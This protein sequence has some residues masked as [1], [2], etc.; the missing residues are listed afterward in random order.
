[1][2]INH[3]SLDSLVTRQNAAQEAMLSELR[4]GNY[5]FDNPLVKL[6]PYFINPYAAVVLFNTPEEVAVTVRVLGK[7]KEG[8]MEHTFPRA[9]EHVLPVLGLYGDYAN[10][11][12]IELYRGAKHTIT[13]QTEPIGSQVPELVRMETTAGYLRDQI[14]IVSPALDANSA[15]LAPPLVVE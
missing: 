7:E 12:E 15:A 3:V 5:T 4:N 14:I 1:M 6:N 9:K 10:T 2:A 8:T 11:V 13:I